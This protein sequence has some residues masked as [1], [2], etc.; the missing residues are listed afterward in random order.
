VAP[1]HVG[2]TNY[3]ELSQLSEHLDS[4]KPVPSKTGKLV[5]TLRAARGTMLGFGFWSL[6]WISM[7]V[8]G[9]ET[10]YIL[11]TPMVYLGMVESVLCLIVAIVNMRWTITLIFVAISPAVSPVLLIYLD[12]I[13]PVGR[14]LSQR[15][16]FISF[17]LILA[18]LYLLFA[19]F[20]YSLI[21]Q[22]ARV[23]QRKWYNWV[24]IVVAILL[25]ISTLIPVPIDR[26]SLLGYSAHC[27]ITPLSTILCWATAVLIHWFGRKKGNKDGT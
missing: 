5:E 8:S 4:I 18:S 25:G 17:P 9:L 23:I 27:P 19:F 10:L 11:G 15:L 2:R 6:V 7:I 22:S 3:G 14:P 1:L 24:G 16:F 21:K 12:R 13:F 20:E 26:Y